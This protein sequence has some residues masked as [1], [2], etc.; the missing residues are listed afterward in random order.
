MKFR[1]IFA[2]AALMGAV[3]PTV[4]IAQTAPQN[5][6][7]SYAKLTHCAAFN[8]LLGQVMSSGTDKDKPE[9]KA[10]AETFTN[11]AAALIVVATVVSKKDSKVV[12][13]DVFAQNGAMLKSLSGAGAAESL[14]RDNLETCNNLG[15]AAYAT[16]TE[17]K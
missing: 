2:A 6:E 12:T 3:A 13:D 14:V 10:S 7:L 15:K 5:D 11:Q 9:N 4:S 17:K 8:M 1:A 16:I